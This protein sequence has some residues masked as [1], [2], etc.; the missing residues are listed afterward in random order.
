MTVYVD[1]MH[2][3]EMGRLGWMK[4]SHM[5]ADTRDE[6]VAMAKAIGVQTKWIQHKGGHNEHFDIAKGKRDLAIAAGAVPITMRQCS[7]MVARRRETGQLGPPDEAL[8]W[9]TSRK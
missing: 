4:M 6:L 8:A 3:V 7:A 5:I 2:G 1:D 9:L